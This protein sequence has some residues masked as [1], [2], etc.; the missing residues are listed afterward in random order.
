MLVH[1]SEYQHAVNDRMFPTK[2][3]ASFNKHRWATFTNYIDEIELNV[4]LSKVKQSVDYS[5]RICGGCYITVVKD[6]K[7]VNIRR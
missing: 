5:R 4:E 2:K 1:V 3:G 6:V 7:C